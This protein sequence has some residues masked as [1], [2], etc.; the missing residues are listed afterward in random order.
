MMKLPHKKPIIGVTI[1]SSEEKTYAQ[2]P[3][4]ALRMQYPAS[5]SKFGCVPILLP[6]DSLNID[7]YLDII[8]GLVFVGGDFD[9][10][11]SYYGEK[12]TSSTVIVNNA[13]T[14][15]ELAL[16]KKALLLD[17]PILGICAG[18]QLINVALGGTLI[19]HIE[20]EYGSSYHMQQHP[21]DVP[22]HSIH[23]ERST[24]LHNIY[25]QNQAMVNSSHHQAIRHLGLGVIASAKSMDGIIEAIEVPKHKFCLGVQWHPEYL[26]T[27]IDVSIF[28]TFLNSISFKS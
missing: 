25:Q 10:D 15:F 23:I 24:L 6:Y 2:Y 21:K 9:I 18:M 8:D 5:I 14:S 4:Y 3:W 26:A 16:I 12:I 20:E 27:E 17:K 22:S 1:D 11:P 7:H 28:K 13:R 19:Q